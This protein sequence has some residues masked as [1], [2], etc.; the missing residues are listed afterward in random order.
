MNS[1]QNNKPKHFNLPKGY[2]EN[3]M[4]AIKNRIE[5]VEELSAYPLLAKK[6]TSGFETPDNYFQNKEAKLENLPYPLLFENSKKES[7]FV[8]PENYEQQLNDRVS[9][10]VQTN[11]TSFILDPKLKE[12]PFNLPNGYFENNV[13]ELKGILSPSKTKVIPFNFVKIG[14]A[15]A[16]VLVL[17]L[18]VVWFK[19]Y[20]SIPGNDC[21]S[22]AC[23]DVNQLKQS[24]VLEGIET[25]DLYEAVDVAKLKNALTKKNVEP[26][27]EALPDS[28]LDELID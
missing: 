8:T 3:S 4:A 25:E 15:I 17:V 28:L 13:N 18:S 2:F 23:M 24:K 21:G 9:D 6:Y 10:L 19:N 11:T 26:A 7:G 20:Y 1:D 5:C 14:Y 16:A 27:T 12:T 22:L